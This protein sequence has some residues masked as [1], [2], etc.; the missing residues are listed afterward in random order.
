MPPSKRELARIRT[1][2]EHIFRRLDGRVAEAGPGGGDEFNRAQNHLKEL[3]VTARSKIQDKA[4]VERKQGN[5]LEVRRAKN[6]VEGA[7]GDVE[8]GLGKLKTVLRVVLDSP[9]VT[10]KVKE[11]RTHIVERFEDL[12]RSL[13]V[14]AAGETPLEVT[15][16]RQTKAVRLEDLKRQYKDLRSADETRND[17]FGEDHPDDAR[18]L[19]EW[20]AEDAKMDRKLEDVVLILD[21]IRLM[22]QNLGKE[23]EMRD[24]VM[25][26][27][28]KE[29]A[30]TNK[31]LQ[32]QS[33]TLAAVLRKFR[34]PGKV[35]LDIC[36]AVLLL[37]LVGVII[38]LA[39]NGKNASS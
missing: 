35:C 22:N 11:E 4:K 26:D 29:A 21:E 37:G 13:C 19:G 34:S 39:V 32:Q 9:K 8:D 10:S 25:R 27:A 1:R 14:A 30:D 7:L 17:M 3:I 5:V 36:L 18:V 6:E 28:T 24:A 38:M 23:L 2:L 33:K 20:Q 31:A 16:L 12:V 15:P